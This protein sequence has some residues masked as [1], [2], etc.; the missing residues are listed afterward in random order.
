MSP[1]DLLRQSVKYYWRTNGAVVLGVAI[2]VAVLAGALLVGDSVR[3]SLRDL[4][5][6][7]LGRTDQIVASTG[8]FREALAGDLAADDAFSRTFESI[9]PIVVTQGIVGEQTGGRRVPRVAIYGVDERFWRFHHV[10][11]AFSGVP[12]EG[13]EALVSE[14][15]ASEL[16]IVKGGAIVV[17]VERPSAIPLESLHAKKDAAGRTMRLGVHGVLGA[18]DLG[19]FSLRPQQGRVRAV[20]VPLRRLQQ[21]MG[22]SGRVNTLLAAEQP[23]ARPAKDALNTVLRRRA[24][25]EDVGLVVRP[26]EPVGVLAVESGAGLLDPPRAAAAERAAAASAMTAQSVFTY[27]VNSLR[28][29]SREIPYSLVTGLD[30]RTIAPSV[31]SDLSNGSPPPIV[32]NDWAARDLGVRAGDPLSLDY[33]VWEDP[34]QLLTRR[35]DFRV[36]AVVPLSGAAA[37]RQLAPVYPGISESETF[38]D[39]DPPFPIDLR[40]VRKV[41]EDYWKTY[42]TT[43]KAFVPFETARRL[44]QSRYGDRTSL[45]IAAPPGQPLGDALARYAATLRQNID[46]VSLGLAAQQVR[47]EGLTASRGA[48]DFGEYFTYFSFF[49]VLSALLLAALFFRLGVEQRAKEI[50]LLRAVGFSTSRVR[51]LFIREGLLLAAL[52]SLA[53]VVGA[54]GYAWLMMTGLG[55][56]WSGAVGTS[57]LHL[58][59]APVSLLFGAA[60]AMIAA[61]FCIAWTMRGLAKVSERS[62]VA[63]NLTPASSVVGIPR[64]RRAPAIAASAFGAFGIAL[65]LA[66]A[67]GAIDRTGAFF[68][69]GTSLLVACLCLISLG[70]RLRLRSRLSGRGWRPVMRLGFRNAADRPGR[71]VLAIAVIASATFILISVDSFRRIGVPATDRRS[72]VGG[73][74]LIVDL[75]LPLAHD[76]NS[77]EGR[78]RLGLASASGVTI[79]P[80]RLLPGDDASC[81]NLYTPT[82]PRVLGASRRFIESGRFAFQSSV[83]ST[84][85]ERAN[86]WLLLDRVFQ[87]EGG[88]VIPV[89]AD[90]NSMT[91]VLHKA[92]GEDVVVERDGAPVKL[93][94][95]AALDDSLFQSELITS[96]GHFLGLFSG[97]GG[98][99]VMLVD[100]RPDQAAALAAAINQGGQDLG[101]AAVPTAERLAEFH[102]VEN[103]YIATFQTLGGLGLLI[104]T[105]GLAAVLLRNVLERRRDLAL[106][107]AVGYRQ[108]HVFAIVLAENLFLLGCGLA[109]GAF[110]ALVAVVPAL[111]E[112][113]HGGPATASG[114][115]LVTTVFAAGLVSSA[116]ATRLALRG[117][118][119]SSL[120]AE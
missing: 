60:G 118:L 21:E 75:L 89:I 116:I 46:P 32:L 55:S 80:F 1:F 53:G 99:R 63:G 97:Q 103:T 104:G 4:V 15:L 98:Y 44:W 33:F 17:R 77:D 56:W 120:R 79:E 8:F 40:R 59:V 101:A 37:D 20:F 58:H 82:R 5:V 93:R 38:A 50:G 22:V 29:G 68:G 39:W 85:D 95:V 69:A 57:A 52:G 36:A 10:G 43:P 64:S 13:R 117:S 92:L 107:G 86:P 119:L 83:A 2:A 71:S 109:V 111:F 67:T 62:L 102:R 34:G 3:G 30:L 49:L 114:A 19:E 94:L 84:P 72:G 41:D 48:T 81:L 42:R 100:A 91:Y 14:A 76:P 26:I 61:V 88:P 78:E 23:D 25:L 18:A 105:I 31:D 11:D 113:S 54:V 90:A 7:R 16:A 73:Y 65:V 28:S 115:M 6:Q 74:S 108:G 110:C 24:A 112:R 27:L 47:T 87:D 35:A 9:C 45:R 106:L 12:A 96:D 51:M 66:A 70:L